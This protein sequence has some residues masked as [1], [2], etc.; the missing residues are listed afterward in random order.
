MNNSLLMVLGIGIGFFVDRLWISKKVLRPLSKLE[1]AI[2]RINKFDFS[3]ATKEELQPLIMNNDRIS[4]LAGAIFKAQETFSQL[5]NRLKEISAG[6]EDNAIVINKFIDNINQYS[7]NTLAT[8]EELSSS[9]EGTA[10]SSQQI[11]ATTEKINRDIENIAKKALEGSELSNKINDRA[12]KFKQ[13]AINS[14][15][16]STKIY[17]KV[18]DELLKSI[19]E[20]KKVSKID[21]LASNILDIAERTNLL[22][23]NAAIEAA[24]AG[25]AGRGFSVVAEEIKKLSEQT[26]KTVVNIQNIINIVNYSVNNLSNNA[27]QMLNFFEK[28]VANDYKTMIDISEKY[29]N[30]AGLIHELMTTFSEASNK[31]SQSMNTISTSIGQVTNA[32]VDES[33]GI[34][35]I[36]IKNDNLVSEVLEIQNISLKNIDMIQVLKELIS[37][38]EIK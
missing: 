37:S 36:A 7:M 1:N 16:D 6:I 34:E 20:S 4:K 24:R 35:D 22:S 26:S 31:F 5:H 3:S 15:K 11:S 30:D 18:G 21:E 2:N 14:Q 29:N 8:T 23:L 10:A 38:I 9:I 12:N 32:I 33:K 13:N 25:E 17:N 19:E 28:K 27:S